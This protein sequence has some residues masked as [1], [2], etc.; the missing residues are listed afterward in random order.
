MPDHALSRSFPSCRRI[1]CA[2]AWRPSPRASCSGAARE[3]RD[4]LRPH[5]QQRL[6]QRLRRRG[7]GRAR[8]GSRAPSVLASGAPR[9]RHALRGRGGRG[10]R[11]AA[12]ARRFTQN[13]SGS[14]TITFAVTEVAGWNWTVNVDVVRNGAMTILSDG[15]GNAQRH[16]ERAQRRALGRGRAGREPRASARS[17][18]STTRAR[19]APRR[20]RPSTR[21]RRPRSPASA[22]AARR[23]SRSSS[24]SR[25]RRRRDPAGGH[26]GRRGGAAHGPRQRARLLHRRQLPRPGGRTLANDGIFVSAARARA[27]RRGA[28][29]GGPD[30]PRLVRSGRRAAPASARSV[31]R[32][33]G[34]SSRLPRS[35]SGPRRRARGRSRSRARSMKA[36][37]TKRIASG[38]AST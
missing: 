15:T 12:A 11:T 30:R 4:D 1:P 6:D 35:A 14:F 29:R 36:P 23:S 16:A 18:R 38:D 27:G 2:P 25:E 7:C 22:P 26:R 31:R 34:E 37:R 19:R 20:T 33:R 28:A 5:A 3:R 17:A 24:L 21:A 32:S 9:L 10:R 8:S 13:F